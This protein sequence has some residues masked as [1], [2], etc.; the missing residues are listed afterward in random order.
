MTVATIKQIYWHWY[1]LHIPDDHSMVIPEINGGRVGQLY[2]WSSRLSVPNSQT[3]VVILFDFDKYSIH[4]IWDEQACL[5]QPRPL[6]PFCQVW[7]LFWVTMHWCLALDSI[8]VSIFVV[9]LVDFDESE[10]RRLVSLAPTF[11]SQTSV[12]QQL[13]WIITS[14]TSLLL[15]ILAS[16]NNT[17]FY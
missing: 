13:D 16:T 12:S 2:W 10:T 1:C 11:F 6:Q 15:S 7:E 14:H 9:F 5:P 8:A 3:L 17:S 4:R